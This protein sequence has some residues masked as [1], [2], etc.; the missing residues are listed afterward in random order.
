[1]SMAG[2]G[3]KSAMFTYEKPVFRVGKTDVAKE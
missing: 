2:K 1:M 3:T